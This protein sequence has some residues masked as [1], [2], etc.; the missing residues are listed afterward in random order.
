M[1][2]R[3]SPF[4]AALLVSFAAIAQ[5]APWYKWR[6]KLNGKETC[7]Q[8]SPGEGWE[9]VSGPLKSDCKTAY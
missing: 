1:I 9:K 5:A 6:S 3:L 8:V 4:L 7:Q 2:G